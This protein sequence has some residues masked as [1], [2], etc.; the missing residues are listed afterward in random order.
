MQL[1]HVASQ[2]HHCE[3]PGGF[4][5]AAAESSIGLREELVQLLL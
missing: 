3:D 5:W 2:I 1:H 4:S